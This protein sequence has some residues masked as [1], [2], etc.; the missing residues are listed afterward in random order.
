MLGTSSPSQIIAEPMPVPSV[1]TRT[2]PRRPRAAP[3]SDSARPAASASLTTWTSRPSA[4]VK[5]ASAS[6][7]IHDLSMLAAEWTT[8][9]RTM[10]GTVTPTGLL[11]A[12]KLSTM[13]AEDLRHRGRAWRGAG[14]RCGRGRATKSPRSRS[15]G[16]PLMPVPPK[17]M[18]KGCSMGT[19]LSPGLSAC[20]A[21]NTGRDHRPVARLTNQTALVK[22]VYR[23]Y[24]HVNPTAGGQADGRI[25]HP[26]R[27]QRHGARRHDRALEGPQ[28]LPVADRPGGA[29]PRLRRLRR[30][31][32]HRLGRVVLGRPDRHPRHR[33]GDR[34]DRRP[35][36]VQPAR[37]RDR[38]AGAGPLLPLDHLPLPAHPVRRIPRRDGP[39]RRVGRVRRAGRPAPDRSS[40]R[41]AWRS[42]S[43]AS[44]ASA[45]TPPTSSATRRRPTSA[46]CR[47]S[48]WRRCSTATSTSS[49]TA[50]TTSGSPPPRTPRAP[51]WAR[52][53][54]SSGRAR[55]AGR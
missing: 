29:E 26:T 16:A 9:W 30:V 52:T 24:G 48:R 13:R 23:S 42:R 43:A 31:R 39:R 12:G 44:A 17:S 20:D 47:R 28:A 37:R 40:T 35:R 25:S 36:P 21:G 33:A 45:S 34:P 1:M 2:W 49:T 5:I 50:A 46:G 18:P 55:S 7:P 27:S 51:G 14:C 19:N 8:P 38:G 41:S 32:R 53:S 22:E 15:T 11:E 54:T 10:P 3:Y 4:S 6:S